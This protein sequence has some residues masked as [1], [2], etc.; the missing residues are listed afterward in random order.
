[1]PPGN[2][3]EARS[4]TEIHTDCRSRDQLAR[5]IVWVIPT[6]S[7]THSSVILVITA[8]HELIG[9]DFARPLE[10][11]RTQLQASARCHLLVGPEATPNQASVESL[12]REPETAKSVYSELNRCTG[13]CDAD[14]IQNNRIF[15]GYRTINDV[16]IFANFGTHPR[17]S[18]TI[19]SELFT[20]IEYQSI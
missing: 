12:G 14:F 8:T 6:Q 2:Y 4:A 9:L 7:N 11:S 17:C 15:L 20:D 5:M 13:R 18:V 19:R 10:L 1:M 3:F 16:P